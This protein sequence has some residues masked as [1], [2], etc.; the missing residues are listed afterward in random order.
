MFDSWTGER[1]VAYRRL[2]QLDDASG[3]AVTVQAMAATE[4]AGVLFS[5][6]PRRAAGDAF[7]I[8]AVRGGGEALVSGRAEPQRYEVPRSQRDCPES[9]ETLVGR[10]AP[11]PGSPQEP[12]LGTAELRELCSLAVRVESLLGGFADV[13][14]GY[15]GGQAVLFQARRMDE[16]QTGERLAQVRHDELARLQRSA[17]EHGTRLWV[18]H[19]L[20]DTLPAPTPLTWDLVRRWMSGRGGYGSMYRSL[21]YVPSQRVCE[22]GFLELVAGRVYADPD[23]LSEILYHGLPLGYDLRALQSDPSLLEQGPTSF[24]PEH[25]DGWLLF[26]LP[27]AMWKLWRASRRVR[28]ESAEVVE[29]FE[30]QVLPGVLVLCRR[31][32][33]RGLEPFG[34]PRTGGPAGATLR[35]GP[36]R[37]RCRSLAARVLCR[38][39]ACTRS[40]DGWFA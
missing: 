13:E 15:A 30:Q 5:C 22:Q 26:R 29:R 40:K 35:A 27:S 11:G 33:P 23:R 36:G 18:R 3:T 1:A 17:A 9:W 25:A 32:T 16:P 34:R 19:N 4:A 7:V 8:E 2:H 24:A 21:G 14:W 10:F 37:I 31:T 39:G 38:P 6:D 12:I 28:R 20:G